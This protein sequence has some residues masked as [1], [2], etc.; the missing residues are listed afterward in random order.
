MDLW[1]TKEKIW[2][3]PVSLTSPAADSQGNERKI[4]SFCLWRLSAQYFDMNCILVLAKLSNGKEG[5]WWIVSKR[6][7]SA[8]VVSRGMLQGISDGTR[9]S[10]VRHLRP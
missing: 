3:N 2:G 8:V 5:A 9:F 6:G 10:L 1:L 4:V 7:L